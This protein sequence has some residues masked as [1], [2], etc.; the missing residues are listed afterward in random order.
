MHI[1]VLEGVGCKKYNSIGKGTKNVFNWGV[2]KN[3]F[4]WG[5]VQKI[6]QLGGCKK[7]NLFMVSAKILIRLMGVMLNLIFWQRRGG[8]HNSI[9]R[10]GGSSIIQLEGEG[11]KKKFVACLS[12]IMFYWKS[13]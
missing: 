12:D 9:G 13:P 6:I 11:N 3:L 8:L 7:I 10:G 5:G 4:N 2:W 1:P